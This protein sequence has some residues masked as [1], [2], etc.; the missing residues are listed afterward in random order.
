MSLKERL[1]NYITEYFTRQELRDYGEY[2]G[3]D[4][5]NTDRQLRALTEEK[6]IK[7]IFK[8]K[9]IIGYE[10]IGRPKNPSLQKSS[11]I[12]QNTLKDPL[13]C[14]IVKKREEALKRQNSP[15]QPL[16]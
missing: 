15:Q 14:H 2:L 6:R 11:E 9:Y 13:P 8:G 16:L 12:A 10:P 5:S 4:V 7:P 1:K 3:Y